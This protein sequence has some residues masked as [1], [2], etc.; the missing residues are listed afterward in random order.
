M[1][2]L[3]A[4]LLALAGDSSDDEQATNNNVAVESSS[5]KSGSEAGSEAGS[6]KTKR[7]N[8]GGRGRTNKHE[9]SDGDEGEA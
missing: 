2:D 1:A 7:L 3:D 9:E 4:D 8:N 5:S 6:P